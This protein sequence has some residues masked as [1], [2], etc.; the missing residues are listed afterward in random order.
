M[1]AACGGLLVRLL[2]FTSPLSAQP[3]LRPLHTSPA[4]IIVDDTSTPVPLRGLNRSGTGSGNAEATSTDAEYAAQNQ[5]LS[6]N[7]VRIFVNAAW[8]NSNVQVPI[9]R[10]AYQTYIDQ[11]IQ[12]AKKYGNYVLILKA[13]Q[14]PDPPCGADGKNCPAP[15]QGDLNCQATPSVCLAQDTTGNSIDAAFNFWASFAKKYAADAAILYDTW[16]D[17]HGIDSNTWSDNQNQLIAVIRTYAPQSLI[18]VEDTGAAFESIAGGTLADFAWSNIVWNFHLYNGPA[19]S[20]ANPTSPRYAN[21][22]SNFDRLVSYAQQHGHAAAISEW[23]GCNDTDPYHTNITSYAKSR[24]VALAYF[25]STNLLTQTGSTYSLSATG[26]KVAQ[27]YTSFAS[28]PPT[29]PAITLIAN[30]EGEAPL[31]APNTW[32]EVK[33]SN[34]APAGDIRIWQGPDFV[35]NQMPTQLDGVSV[36]VNGKSA[37]I[38]YI[39][40][41]QVNILTPPDAIQGT[42][43]VQLTTGGA[44]SPVAAVQAQA[45]SPS[46][47]IFGAGPYVAA[48]HL[49]STLVGPASMSVPGFTFS[50]A[51]PGETILLFANG[52]G[53]TSTPV[54]SGSLTQGGTIS[55]SPVI[56]IGSANATVIFA[57]LAAAGQFQFNIVVPSS[58]A[59]GDQPITA[60]YNG[61][62]TQ[63]G[64]SITIQH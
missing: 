33:G 10:T 62:T 38:Y 31:I 63:S 49:D 21:W 36:K 50:P 54:V 20:C 14:F 29:G 7:L 11:L 52:F 8:W 48:V 9:A 42:V 6:M 13:G 58:L 27:A 45:L 56:K 17:M 40:P 44:T 57:G 34:L 12:R 3:T 18:F 32:V 15:N 47:F 60:T 16:E 30:A 4:G 55:P 39:S 64:T 53:P 35:N 2:L 59:D 1:L 41:T 22:P 26:A 28:G 19:G 37:F 61:T 43:Q 24:S 25:D 46:F 51:K 5:L 23:G